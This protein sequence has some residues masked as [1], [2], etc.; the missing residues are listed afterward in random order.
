VRLTA[1]VGEA[2]FRLDSAAALRDA[3]DLAALGASGMRAADVP[4][5]GARRPRRRRDGRGVAAARAARGR[6]GRRGSARLGG[7][8]LPAGTR[9]TAAGTSGRP[10]S[11]R[12]TLEGA[13]PPVGVT[14]AGAVRLRVDADTAWLRLDAPARLRLLPG[15]R[16]GD[17]AIVDLD[18]DL[19][20]GAARDGVDLAA[21]VP[22]SALALTRVERQDA[23][24]GAPFRERST[25]RGG[26]VR[27]GA[28]GAERPLGPGDA[29]RLTGVRGTLV[30]ARAADTSV[31]VTFR[32]AWPARAPGWPTT[33]PT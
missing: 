10:G 4:P 8:T 25:V 31:V 5:A 11:S 24:G 1:V 20:A 29:L 13:L 16:E 18:L 9:V 32:G 6:L 22:V 30:S 23:P 7:L 2:T 3:L 17:S 14:V 27:I 21:A 33:R 28:G 19:P 26:T 15:A 12:L